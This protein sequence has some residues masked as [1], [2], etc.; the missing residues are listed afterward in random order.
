MFDDSGNWLVGGFLAE[1]PDATVKEVVETLAG[2]RVRGSPAQVYNLKSTVGKP[3]LNGYDSLIQAKKLAG[4]VEVLPRRGQR[5]TF[6]QNSCER[7]HRL[8]RFPQFSY[9]CSA[10]PP[11]RMASLPNFSLI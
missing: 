8:P 10:P 6:C 7:F 1:N 4:T 2:Q 5:S 9:A 11:R 3:K